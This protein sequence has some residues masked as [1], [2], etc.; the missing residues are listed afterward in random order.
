MRTNN[1]ICLLR[2]FA[3]RTKFISLTA[4]LEHIQRQLSRNESRKIPKRVQDCFHVSTSIVAAARTAQLHRN[5]FTSSN[6]C[7]HEDTIFSLSSGHG[8]CGVAVIRIS[9]PQSIEILRR[10]GK[11]KQKP[12]PRLAILRK[13]VDPSNGEVIDKGIILFF[14]SKLVLHI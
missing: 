10:I 6:L 7:V 13:L 14:P 8:K 11:F 3:L 4:G 12:T 9:G 1:T 2:Q 5:F